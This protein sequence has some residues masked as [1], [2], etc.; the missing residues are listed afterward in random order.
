MTEPASNYVSLD[1]AAKMRKQAIRVWM[2]GFVVVTGWVL[3]TVAAPLA[4]ANGFV[5]VSS[6]L[7]SFFSYICHQISDRSFHIEGEQF[8]VCS[9]CFGVYFGLAF[10]FAIYP[11]WRNITEIEPLP[12]FWLFLSLIPIGIDWSLTIFGIWENTHL[13][14]FITGLI[15]GVACATYIVPAIVEITRNLTQRKSSHR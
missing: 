5:A 9:R 8:A 14:R 6:P 2:A 13:S 4:K 15:L 10:G 3:L 1:L 11:L 7:Y 12:R